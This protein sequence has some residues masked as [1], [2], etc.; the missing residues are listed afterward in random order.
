MWSNLVLICSFGT[1]NNPYHYH[2]R[3]H[4]FMSDGTGGGRSVENRRTFHF[5]YDSY[6]E[7][8]GP[9]SSSANLRS[10]PSN[11]TSL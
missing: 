6:Y 8:G 10:S 1:T 2:C 9:S 11:G 5:D 4:T 3:R 7:E